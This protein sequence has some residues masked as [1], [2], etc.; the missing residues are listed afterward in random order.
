MVEDLRQQLERLAAGR[1]G[2]SH[3]HPAVRR[4]SRPIEELVGGAV[5]ATDHGPC[6]VV[7]LTYPDGYLHGQ[8]DIAAALDL[9]PHTVAA[10]GRNEELASLDLKRTVFLDVETTG[11]AGG[12]GTYAFLVG[13]GWFEGQ[14]FR[15]RQLFMRDYSEERGL[16][17]LVE[18]TLAPLSGI[19][20]FNGKAFDVPLLGAAPGPA[21]HGAPSLAPATG[22]LWALQSGDGDPRSTTPW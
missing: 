4:P 14:D 7:D 12:A 1:L 22:E 13:L 3:L 6:V 8:V 5:V 9:N 11:L 15:L 18:E 10:I 2:T 17:S 21:A 19:V 16:I 20:S